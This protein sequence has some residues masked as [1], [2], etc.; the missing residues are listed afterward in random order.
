MG[1]INRRESCKMPVIKFTIKGNQEDPS[2]NP[3]PYFR[4]T[5]GSKWSKGA[6]RYHEWTNYVR[7]NYLDAIMP[8]KKVDRAMLGEMHDF[9]EKKPIKAIDKKITMHTCIFFKNKA[10]ADSDNIFKGI[11]DALFMNDKYVAG[12]F[13]YHYSDK[14]K[15]EV[16]INL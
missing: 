7:A 3:I 6:K 14:G 11:A 13:D 4:Q 10:H 15:V 1:K 8:L 5:Q 9:L 2:G 16:T 12:S